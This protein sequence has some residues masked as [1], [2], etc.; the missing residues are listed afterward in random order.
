[1]QRVATSTAEAECMAMSETSK[2]LLHQRQSLAEL[3]EAMEKPTSVFVDNDAAIQIAKN[4]GFAQRSKSIRM[5]HHNT[6]DM[7]ADCTVSV[8]QIE[9]RNDASDILTKAL[10]RK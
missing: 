8:L 6:P 7:T 2:E 1:M 3:G 10:P 5:A 4:P 9:S